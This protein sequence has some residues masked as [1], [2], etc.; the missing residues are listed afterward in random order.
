VAKLAGRLQQLRKMREARDEKAAGENTEGKKA[1]E[2]NPEVLSRPLPWEGWTELSPYVWKRT[3]EVAYPKETRYIGGV[4]IESA[5]ILNYLVFY[6]F[7]TTGLSGGAGTLVFLAGFGRFD[8]KSMSIDQLMLADYPG[9]AEFIREISRYLSDK[10]IFVSYNGKGFDRHVLLNRLR[11]HG[12]R[13]ADMRRQLDLLYPTRKIWGK[14]LERCNLG[15]IEAHVLKVTRVLD[16]PG[17][18]IPE[19][20]QKFLRTREEGCMQMVVAHHVQDIKSLAQLLFHIEKVASEPHLLIDSN[21]GVGLG[22]M[23]ASLGDPRGLKILEKELSEGNED[24]GRIL[25]PIYKRKKRIPELRGVLN[26]MTALRPGYFQI[27]ETAKLLEHIDKDPKA[28]MDLIQPLIQRRALVSEA[29]LK[30]LHYRRN[31]LQRKI[32]SP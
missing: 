6:D 5:D 11:I 23:L 30:E 8:G 28:A 13:N 19:C 25:V 4:L 9:E 20:Y 31:R 22:R 16:I 26:K 27:V 32:E 15:S 1:E 17:A 24:A 12:Y 10:N 14:S 18:L 2:K 29:R 21:A 3:I 7:E